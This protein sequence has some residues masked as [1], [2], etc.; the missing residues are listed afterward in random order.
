MDID[1][2]EME[3]H[4][5]DGH[6]GNMVDQTINLK[7]DKFTMDELIFTLQIYSV[8]YFFCWFIK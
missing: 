7:N 2:I 1:E 4:D 3:M 8:K 6:N 5:K